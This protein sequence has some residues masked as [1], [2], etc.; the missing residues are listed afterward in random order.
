MPPGRQLPEATGSLLHVVAS[1]ASCRRDGHRRT[2]AP[3]VTDL[4]RRIPRR[5]RS[6]SE[7]PAPQSP[8]TASSSARLPA[9]C[10]A[11]P[12]RTATPTRSPPATPPPPPCSSRNASPQCVHHG[13]HTSTNRHSSVRASLS[14]NRS[15]HPTRPTPAWTGAG[16]G[17]AGSAMKFDTMTKPLKSGASYLKQRRPSAV[18]RAAAATKAA[19]AEVLLNLLRFRLGRIASA[20]PARRALRPGRES[21]SG[22]E[23]ISRAP[24]TSPRRTCAYRRPP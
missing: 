16:N 6:S 10:S 14:T 7:V 23:P 2:K 5:S 19:F 4:R 3:S 11:L 24:S 15:L 20:I 8:P 17:S 12:P 9:G 13:A 18:L 22:P 1:R 21:L